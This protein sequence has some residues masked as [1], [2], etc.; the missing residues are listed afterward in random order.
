MF[1]AKGILFLYINSNSHSNHG[2]LSITELLIIDND[3]DNKCTLL[4][5]GIEVELKQNQYN[6]RIILS[7]SN[8]DDIKFSTQALYLQ[9]H[10]PI[11]H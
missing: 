6:M 4:G 5:G 11:L 9:I 3:P 8:F 10:T 1:C 2:T 7:R